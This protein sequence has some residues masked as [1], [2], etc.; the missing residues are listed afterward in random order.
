MPMANEAGTPAKS[1]PIESV[2]SSPAALEYTLEVTTSFWVA[3]VT[4]RA[5]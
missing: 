2:S 3:Q 4:L 1:W 5:P